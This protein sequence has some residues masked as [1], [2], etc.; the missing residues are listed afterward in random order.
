MRIN[1]VMGFFLP[2]PPVAGGATEK[3]WH[4][5]ALEFARRGHSVTILSRQW[6]GWPDRETR[7]GVH[8]V[9]LRGCNHTRRLTLNLWHDFWWSLRVWRALPPADVTVVNC[10]ALPVWLG[11]WRRGTGRLAVMTGRV[12]KGQYRLYRRLDRVLAVSSTVR[13]AVL[14]ENHSLVALTRVVGYPIRWSELARPHPSGHGPV[15]IGYIGRLNRE[16]GLDLLVAALGMLAKQ[17]GLPAWRVVICGPTSVAQGGSGEEYALQLKQTLAA[18]LPAGSFELRPAEFDSGRLAE[19]YRSLDVFC[20]PSLA[21][22]GETFGV[23]IVEAMAAGA[24]PIVSD[25]PCFLDFLHPAGN[26]E[27]FA[28]NDD[29]AP[30]RLAQLIA[31]LLADPARRARLA[32]NAR[33]T[34][35][36]YDFAEF[37]TRLLE[38]F[39]TLK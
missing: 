39:S 2:M 10:V 27:V 26:G 38:D 13:D 20:Y 23:A 16:K 12:P 17:P 9:R 11:W 22:A 21:L 1:L 34:A 31:A 36:R 6:P 28:R 37:A 30:A 8:H 35:Q 32:D 15:T 33:A 29:D 25:L 18:S 5:L 14:A 7:D 24:V 4:E 19:T 3:S